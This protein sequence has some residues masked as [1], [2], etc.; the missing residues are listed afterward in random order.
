MRAVV[1]RVSRASVSVDGQLVSSIERGFLVLLGVKQADTREDA[2]YLA[3]KIAKLRVFSDPTGKMNWALEQVDGAVLAVSQFTLYADTRGGNRPSFTQA[4]SAEDGRRLYREFCELLR[5]QNLE[6]QE[7]I[8]QAD[9][10]V[11]LLNDGP[12]T[13]LIDSSERLKP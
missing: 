6:V 13:I 5:D 8:F 9:M 4:A 11:E 1:Q 12:V 7:G 3:R 2:A 10:K